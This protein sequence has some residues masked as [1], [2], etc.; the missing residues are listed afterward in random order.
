MALGFPSYPPNTNI[1]AQFNLNGN[2]YTWNGKVWSLSSKDLTLGNLNAQAIIIGN[3]GTIN[4]AQIITTATLNRFVQTNVSVIGGDDI[5]VTTDTNNLTVISNTSTFQTV[6]ARGPITTIAIKVANTTNSVSTITGALTVSGGVGIEKDLFVG[7]TVFSNGKY[8]LTTSSFYETVA[9]GPDILITATQSIVNGQGYLVISNISTL[10]TVT[11]RGNSTDKTV[12]ITN[13]TQSTSTN[14]GALTVSG[15]VGVAG[16]VFAN[17]VQI[18]ASIMSSSKLTINTTQATVIDI[19]SFI[20]FRS[21]KYLIQVE[22]GQ[23]KSFIQVI[24]ILLMVDN[25]GTVYATEYGVL[26]NK[27]ELGEFSADVQNDNRV[28]LYFTPKYSGP[29]EITY[30]RTTVAF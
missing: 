20:D 3:T 16:T 11:E 13:K 18:G 8:V 1:G 10:Q 15:G 27:G 19:Y 7:G 22:S 2:I 26:T 5:A 28:R 4:G 6:T 12:T 9:S 21:T 24:E 17:S 25:D 29:T 14:T 30:F 23:G